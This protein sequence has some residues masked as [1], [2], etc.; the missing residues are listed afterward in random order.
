MLI[1]V[2]IFVYFFLIF[3]FLTLP[4]IISTT[5]HEI[6]EALFL[7]PRTHS[8][9]IR[10][11]LDFTH[12]SDIQWYDVAN[13]RYES[14]R[15]RYYRI[16]GS[17]PFDRE[18]IC[19]TISQTGAGSSEKYRIKIRTYGNKKIYFMLKSI[20]IIYLDRPLHIRHAFIR[21]LTNTSIT[22]DWEDDSYNRNANISHYELVLR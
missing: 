21:N 4:T 12:S 20:I 13:H 18:F 22:I 7:D 5:V 2:Q 6:N 8:A 15:G 17:Q 16:N 1:N 14:D 19:S 11:P 3:Q 10:C 9:F